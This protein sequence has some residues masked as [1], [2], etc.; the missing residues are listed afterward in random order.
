[1]AGPNTLRRKEC[2]PLRTCGECRYAGHLAHV[3]VCGR[4]RMRV[5]AYLLYKKICSIS[6]DY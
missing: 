4:V 5:R 2:G 6:L 3:R 1:M